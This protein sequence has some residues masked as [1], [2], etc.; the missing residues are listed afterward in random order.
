VAA[1]AAPRVITAAANGKVF[2]PYLDVSAG[3]ALFSLAGKS[4]VVSRHYTLGFIAPAAGCNAAWS[5]RH[6]LS[7][8]EAE[9]W[10]ANVRGLRAAGG[11]VVISFGGPAGSELANA[12]ADVASLQSQYQAVV[13]KYALRYA[14]FDI[15]DFTPAAIDK[16]NAALKGLEAANPA[17]KVSYTLPVTETGFDSRQTAVLNGA[18]FRGVR[19]DRVNLMVM[20]YDHPV[21]DMYSAAVSGA[22]AA[23]A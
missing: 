4:D 13:D 21:A 14:D 9:A 23:R 12:C 7:S 19:I 2:A 17:L 15:E 3:A 6:L 5:G 16:R 20:D 1:T 18:R 22:Q 10:V 8:V 11:D